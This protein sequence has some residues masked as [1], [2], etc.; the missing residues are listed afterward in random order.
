MKKVL[1]IW[2][3]DNTLVYNSLIVC[4]EQIAKDL[5]LEIDYYPLAEKRLSAQF[6]EIRKMNTD[7]LWVFDMAGFQ[8]TT[9]QEDSIYTILPQKQ[10]HFLLSNDKKYREYLA[11][12]LSLNMFLLESNETLFRRYKREYSHILNLDLMDSL[13][14]E[15]H[16]SEEQMD[17]NKLAMKK[18][19]KRIHEEV[20]NS[21]QLKADLR[22]KTSPLGETDN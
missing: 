22:L 13:V 5:D 11:Q 12:A 20:E 4:L 3:K 14:A 9:L 10:I 18:E 19:I 6:E 17:A 16:P 1:V 2:D 8:Q 15:K 21:K 7:Y